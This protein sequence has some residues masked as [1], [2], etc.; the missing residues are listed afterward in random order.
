VSNPVEAGKRVF[1]KN[2]VGCH[3]ATGQGI[4]GA[5]PPLVG[6]EWVTGPPET[7]VRI[8]LFGLQ[9]PVQVRGATFNGAMPAWKDVLKDE[10]I[11]AVATYIREWAPNAAPAVPADQVAAQRK[12]LAGRTAPWTAAELTSAETSGPSPA[13]SAPA[14]GGTGTAATQRTP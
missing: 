9:G 3:Q 2:C 8:L 1:D 6:S 10:E 4:P 5:F 14:G 13:V 7:V 12:A 11:A